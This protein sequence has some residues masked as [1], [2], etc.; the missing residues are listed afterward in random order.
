MRQGPAC[1][2]LAGS[3]NPVLD[4]GSPG[5]GSLPPLLQVAVVEAMKMRNVL[6]TD[7]EGVVAS[8]EATAG[9]VV[10]ADQVVVRFE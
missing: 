8:V 6:R 2:P 1:C 4:H 7:V 9:S 5:S 3:I 10:G